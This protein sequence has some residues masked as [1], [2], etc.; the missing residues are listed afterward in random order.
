MKGKRR[1][2]PERLICAILVIV[3][4]VVAVW[5][6]L[7]SMYISE[8]TWSSAD[9]F[10]GST[11]Q[12]SQ[13]TNVVQQFTAHQDKMKEIQLMIAV[14]K[15]KKLGEGVLTVTLHGADGAVLA[16]K[17]LTNDDI[18]TSQ[19]LLLDFEQQDNS[20]HKLYTLE[21][22]V[23]GFTDGGAPH[24][25]TG[26]ADGEE[27]GLS[28][29]IDGQV[30]QETTLYMQIIYNNYEYSWELPFLILLLGLIAGTMYPLLPSYK[31]KEKK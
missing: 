31:E 15:S 19:M 16:T 6:Y 25:R 12:I 27:T 28:L 8:T 24:L 9:R 30:K 14:G 26:A 23:E 17:A 29:T 10:S 13:E 4:I 11:G 21:A 1:I 5:L 20:A 2:T 18:E 3:L 22:S 7:G